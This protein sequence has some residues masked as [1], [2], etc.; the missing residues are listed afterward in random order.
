M[1]PEIMR[2]KLNELRMMLNDGEHTELMLD[3]VFLD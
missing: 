3:D 1:T 2:Y